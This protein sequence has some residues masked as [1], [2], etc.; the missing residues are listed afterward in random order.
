MAYDSSDSF[1]AKN[2]GVYLFVL[3]FNRCD[4]R[5]YLVFVRHF[6][7]M[8]PNRFGGD[9]RENLLANC[10]IEKFMLF[11]KYKYVDSNVH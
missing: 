4:C 3:H 10:D 6:G 8:R 7:V 2:V 1:F 11:V 9:G 5:I